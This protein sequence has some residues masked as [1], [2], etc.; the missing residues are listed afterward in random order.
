MWHMYPSK[1]TP[2]QNQRR[3]KERN[4]DLKRNVHLQQQRYSKSYN[5]F[6]LILSQSRLHK[7]LGKSLKRTYHR[8]V[9]L[10]LDLRFQQKNPHILKLQCYKK[11]VSVA[12]CSLRLP[13]FIYSIAER[14]L[15]EQGGSRTAAKEILVIDCWWNGPSKDKHSSFYRYL[16]SI[17]LKY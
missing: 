15:S 5:P 17:Y 16:Y 11:I 1:T 13:I 14:V 2:V 12:I 8:L 3:A 10:N 7:N 6:H 9:S 4:F